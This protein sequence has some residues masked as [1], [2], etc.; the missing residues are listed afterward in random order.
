M[1]VPAEAET[2]GIHEVGGARARTLFRVREDASAI[3]RV[4]Y[5]SDGGEPNI[6]MTRDS[7]LLFAILIIGLFCITI[8]VAGARAGNREPKSGISE[9]DR[10]RMLEATLI[11]CF[12]FV[13]SSGEHKPWVCHFK[14]EAGVSHRVVARALKQ[15]GVQAVDG[16]WL[17]ANKPPEHFAFTEIFK[18]KWLTKRRVEIVVYAAIDNWGIVSNE[19]R[20]SENQIDLYMNYVGH[21][22][23]VDENATKIAGE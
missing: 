6:T 3:C 20:L 2:P 10:I 1:K 12:H 11:D 19:Q 23:V 7:G 8:S 4:V 16:F 13:D 18:I 15:I 5:R 14:P 21:R 9:Q 22:W 17:S